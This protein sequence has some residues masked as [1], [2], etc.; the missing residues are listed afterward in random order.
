M[1]MGVLPNSQFGDVAVIDLPSEGVN[2]QVADK[3]KVLHP[4]ATSTVMSSGI[5]SSPIS[6]QLSAD[7]S[8]LAGFDVVGCNEI[9]KSV[10]SIYEQN[11]NSKFNFCESIRDFKKRTDL[12]KELYQLDVLD[13]S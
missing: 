4:V 7:Q 10:I 1:L 8:V 5:T 3:S 2:V 13:G 9:D 12:P 11:I 6:V